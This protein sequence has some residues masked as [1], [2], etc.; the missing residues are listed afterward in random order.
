MGVE[1]YIFLECKQGTVM[2]VCEQ[3]CKTPGVRS[4]RAVTG[5]YDIIAVIEGA[6]FSDLSKVVMGR[7]QD[8]E[9]IKKS[10]TN[11]IIE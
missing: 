3:L 7:I 5:R 4:A 8:I 10:V 2:E 9:G 6:N 11:V 1:A